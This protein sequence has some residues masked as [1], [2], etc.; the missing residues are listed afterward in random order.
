MNDTMLLIA[1]ADIPCSGFGAGVGDDGAGSADA[2]SEINVIATLAT[3]GS[4]G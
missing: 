4:I 3:G 1:L 2:E